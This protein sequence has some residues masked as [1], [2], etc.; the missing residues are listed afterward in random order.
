MYDYNGKKYTY[1]V[2]VVNFIGICTRV[3]S[4]TN[5]KIYV[6]LERDDK[7]IDLILKHLR[8]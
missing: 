8:L 4:R 6:V 5:R 3:T 7:E 1:R 2:I